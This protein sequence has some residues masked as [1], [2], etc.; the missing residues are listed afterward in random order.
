MTPLTGHRKVQRKGTAAA[1]FSLA[2]SCGAAHAQT[3]PT[4]NLCV[5]ALSNHGAKLAIPVLTSQYVRVSSCACLASAVSGQQAAP[6]IRA[7]IETSV[8]ECIAKAAPA[9]RVIPLPSAVLAQ[10]ED[11][12]T[13]DIVARG[14]IGPKLKL[15]SCKRAEYPV[16]AI[17][18]EATGD[19]RLLVRISVYSSVIDAEVTR[20]AGGS[21]AHKFLDVSTLASVLQCKF[22]PASFRG[23][24]L[25]AW[26]EL[27]YRWRL[28]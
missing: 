5:Q 14:F 26:T 20:S 13:T 17:R 16:D 27:E 8:G 6:S 19:T 18:A 21:A 7:L 10:L 25:E 4:E 2:F 11:A 28:Q 3:I 15:E 23:Q 22:E 24:P 12:Y 1:V 9:E